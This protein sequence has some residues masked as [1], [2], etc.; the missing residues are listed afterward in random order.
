LLLHYQ[1]Q[2]ELTSGR[3]VGVEALVRWQDPIEGLISPARFIPLAEETGLIKPLGEWVLNEAC[4]QAVAWQGAGLP[5]F[6]VAVNLSAVQ[7]ADPEIVAI[8]RQALADSGLPAAR[9]ELEITE[10]M[11][12]ADA[13]RAIAVLED[14]RA[15]GVKLAIDDFGTGYS[16]FSYLKRLPLDKLKVDQSFVS[17]LTVDANNAAI[18]EAIIAVAGKLG[19]RVIAE[20][21]ETAEQVEMLRRF[22]CDEV[23][24]YYFS[25]PLPPAEIAGAQQRGKPG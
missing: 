9:L 5:L 15:M 6:I 14:F 8:V 11:L 23:Q 20:G 22:G 18:V 3:M 4:R 24:G 7:L 1:P 25:R 10:S 16:S 2:Y 12:L 13:E 17:D 19:L 21:A